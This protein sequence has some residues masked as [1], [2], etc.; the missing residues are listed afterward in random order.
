MY[1][2]ATEIESPERIADALFGTLSVALWAAFI[3]VL[4]WGNRA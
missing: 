2:R 4:Y 3:L 1:S